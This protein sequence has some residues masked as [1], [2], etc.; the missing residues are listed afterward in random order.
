MSENLE[1]V[2]VRHAGALDRDSEVCII[3][4]TFTPEGFA[5]ELRPFALPLPDAGR[6]RPLLSVRAE[7]DCML[8]AALMMAER[9][10]ERA[11]ALMLL[12]TVAGGCMATLDA[13]NTSHIVVPS[14]DVGALFYPGRASSARTLYGIGGRIEYD[15]NPETTANAF[16]W[17]LFL[18]I[19]RSA[20]LDIPR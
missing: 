19:G 3:W 18:S 16:A 5:R 4:V 8:S 11:I 13:G 14:L 12:A 6:L 17:G 9:F 1:F 15:G 2:A 20:T 10:C 7:Q